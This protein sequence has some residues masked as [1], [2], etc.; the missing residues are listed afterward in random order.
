MVS[1]KMVAKKAGVGIST[2]SRVLNNSGY[3]SEE[4]KEK[5]LSAIK[6]LDYVPNQLG[7]NLKT[8]KSNMI[9][10]FV[11][12]IFHTF[13]SKVA[14]YLENYLYQKG[15]KLIIVNSQGNKKKELELIQMA[16]N[17][18]VEGIIFITNHY[19]SEDTFNGINVVTFDRRIANM[20][21]ITSNNYDASFK[22][23][24]YLYK[25]GCRK[26]AYLGGT[27]ESISETTRRHD[28]YVDFTNKYRLNKYEFFGEVLHGD[29]Y[30]VA[31][32]FFKE[33]LDVDGVF[34]QSDAFAISSYQV[35]HNLY[36]KSIPEDIK[37]I[38]YD[39]I[40]Q[41][42]VPGVTFTVI[43]Q[44]IEKISKTIVDTLLDEINGKRTK[45]YVIIPTEFVEGNTTV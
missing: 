45:K 6:E 28:A 32:V 19:Y 8:Q 26:I 9:A 20:P 43:R 17:G 23:F 37:I 14:Y 3:V 25:S 2:V 31:K 11:P 12:T 44:D 40:V 38:G 27:T 4:T 24:E 5:V 29:E 21:C 13:F 39:G 10:L 30:D 35:L 33:N 7:R 15:Y 42:F 16:R 18:L 41:E 22:A 1:I 34:C 36:G